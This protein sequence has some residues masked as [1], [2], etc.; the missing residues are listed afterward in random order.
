MVGA[1]IE[2]RYLLQ[3]VL[4]DVLFHLLARDLRKL[5]LVV[6]LR[7]FLVKLETLISP[8]GQFFCNLATRKSLNLHWALLSIRLV[9]L[10]FDMVCL[11]L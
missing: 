10:Q 2:S 4:R 8:I 1:S 3:V 6:R 9:I 11:H 5:K 7:S